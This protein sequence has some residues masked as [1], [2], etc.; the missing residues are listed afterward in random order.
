RMIRLHVPSSPDRTL[1]LWLVE[2]RSLCVGANSVASEYIARAAILSVLVICFTSAE[3]RARPSSVSWAIA[4]R[5]PQ[6]A[7]RSGDALLA[8]PLL[9]DARSNSELTLR[10]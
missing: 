6:S 4:S 1:G 7:I 9:R 3:L 5:T 10:A 2:S 8:P